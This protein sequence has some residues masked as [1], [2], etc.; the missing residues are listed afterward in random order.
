MRLR[1]WKGLLLSAFGAL[2]VLGSTASAQPAEEPSVRRGKE[3]FKIFCA[4]CHGLDARGSG[5]VAA[6]LKIQ[7]SDLTH[8]RQKDGHFDAERVF[9][10]VAGRHRVGEKKDMPVFS[11]N[12]EFG[13]VLDIVEY[14]K[15]I[16]Q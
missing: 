15:T 6:L 7:P 4:D 9:K 2:T 5:P 12:L 1:P 16:Q 3:H 8:L 13:T 14:L 11:E 10:A